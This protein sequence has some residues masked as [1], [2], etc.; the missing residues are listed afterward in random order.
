M[1]PTTRM[2]IPITRPILGAREE[3][4]VLDV[5]RSGWL[6]QGPKVAEFEAAVSAYVG[7]RHG[8]ATSSCTTALH[9][10]LVLH[11]LGPGDEVIL[12]SFTFIATANAVLYTGATPVFADI[13]PRTH[14]VDP[15]AVERAITPRSKA[16]MPVHQLGLAA[17]MDALTAVSVRHGIPL[18]EDAAPAI[19]A[20]YRGR[21]VGGLGNTACLS[22]HPRKVIT[23]GE[24]GML[25]TDDEE[26]AERARRLRAHGMS[27]S[28]LRRHH[29]D[30]VLIE[31]Y[32][33]LGYNYRMTDLHAALGLAQIT[34][35]D[36]IIERRRELAAQYGEALR[37]VEDVQL[38]S[39]RPDTPHT[40]QSFMIQLPPGVRDVVMKELLAAGIATR[41]GVM[42]L[43]MEPY[44]RRHYPNVRLPVTE[45]A[46]RNTLLL[47]MYASMTSVEQDYVIEHTLQA[48]DVSRR[49]RRR[50]R[51]A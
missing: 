8:V 10:A 5:L 14:N 44:Y 49:S 19:G 34:R 18:I 11:G 15:R 48:L 47:P 33:E 13:D 4:A 21:R 45:A 36:T 6:V 41:R 22:F 12:P 27:V 1:T 7:A 29:A 20:T 50:S 9:L 40:Y 39:S 28:D 31:E 2:S 51:V 3:I 16:I 23:T 25:L 35:L 26:M 32:D 46:A 42:A 43:H 37:H 30:R 38:P 24:G 17:D